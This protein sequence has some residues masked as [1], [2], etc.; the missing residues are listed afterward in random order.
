MSDI[1]V[2]DS[3]KILKD[4]EYRG[5]IGI[6][7][8]ISSG[9]AR[10]NLDAD[11][12]KNVKVNVTKLVRRPPASAASAAA[13]AVAAATA[14]TPT[15]NEAPTAAPAPPAAA[16]VPA[17]AAAAA[18]PATPVAT[19]TTTTPIPN[20]ESFPFTPSQVNDKLFDFPAPDNNAVKKA[21]D[22]FDRYNNN[23]LKIF[24]SGNGGTIGNK[25]LVQLKNTAI[26][27][28]LRGKMPS[29]QKCQSKRKEYFKDASMAEGIAKCTNQSCN[30]AIYSNNVQREAA[31]TLD[32]CKRKLAQEKEERKAALEERV[33]AVEV[34][35]EAL[36]KIAASTRMHGRRGFVEA[37][38]DFMTTPEMRK[39]IDCNDSQLHIGSELSY[40][41][42]KNTSD[43][44]ITNH[45]NI[46]RDVLRQ[47]LHRDAAETRTEVLEEN[48][49][50]KKALEAFIT[51]AEL[52][53][54]AKKGT[55]TTQVI[56]RFKETRELVIKSNV[57]VENAIPADLKKAGFKPVSINE[58]KNW[59]A[60][61]TFNAK[62]D[63]KMA[64]AEA[65]A[66]AASAAA[67]AGQAPPARQ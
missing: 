47:W 58:I 59:K 6:V 42:T 65:S 36:N 15:G 28:C 53:N 52:A 54:V 45:L 38:A 33:M 61:S 60:E 35:E 56:N 41:F 14:T 5:S 9:V 50:L 63:T 20:I 46:F 51:R 23:D 21:Q 32:E 29:C 16:A 43:D 12:K 39:H 1:N 2:S 48:A 40:F 25:T 67:N 26:E 3:V 8:T 64:T 44:G 18:T 17:A 10:V 37:C 49:N 11:P 24:I 34:P 62:F 57:V 13:A 19:T 66:A 4:G 7:T 22:I 30:H 31:L 27:L 55:V